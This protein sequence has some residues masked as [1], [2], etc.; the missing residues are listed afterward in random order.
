M[1]VF[2]FLLSDMQSWH[3]PEM[4]VRMQMSVAPDIFRN[5]AGKKCPENVWVSP[6]ENTAGQCLYSSQGASGRVDVSNVRLAQNR[7]NTNISGWK[8]TAIHVENAERW[9]ES[10]VFGNNGWC[11]CWCLYTK[12]VISAEGLKHCWCEQV[13]PRKCSCCIIHMWKRL[14]LPDIFRRSCLKTVCLFDHL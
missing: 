11:W 9:Q 7:K 10:R 13:W 5:F 4:Y 14:N 3:V 6:C 12:K 1:L 2:V 8:R